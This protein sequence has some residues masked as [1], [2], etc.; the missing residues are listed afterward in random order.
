MNLVKF[1]V[2]LGHSGRGN[3]VYQYEDIACSHMPTYLCTVN[4]H[5]DSMFSNLPIY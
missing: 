4:S 1:D 5:T 3:P 2:L